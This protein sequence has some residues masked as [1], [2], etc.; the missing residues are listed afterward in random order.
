MFRKKKH[1]NKRMLGCH[2]P[3][4]TSGKKKNKKYL[5]MSLQELDTLGS[6]IPLRT[7][8]KI[9]SAYHYKK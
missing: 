8:I 5:G 7:D 6:S 4:E 3:I 2:Y 1:K 9:I